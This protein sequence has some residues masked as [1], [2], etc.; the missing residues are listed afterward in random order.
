MRNLSLLRKCGHRADILS[1]FAHRAEEW[2]FHVRQAIFVWIEIPVNFIPTGSFSERDTT[3]C[4]IHPQHRHNSDARRYLSASQ[5]FEWEHLHISKRRSPN[6]LNFH[7][8]E[9]LFRKTVW[10]YTTIAPR[11][12]GNQIMSDKSQRWQLILESWALYRDIAMSRYRVLRHCSC[13]FGPGE[14]STGCVQNYSPKGR[15]RRWTCN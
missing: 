15:P 4:P 10:S 6:T 12:K 14:S 13:S 3:Q 1:G 7:L 11:A 9:R 5:F 8:L 2:L